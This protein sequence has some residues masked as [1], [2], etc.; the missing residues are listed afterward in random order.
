MVIRCFLW[1]YIYLSK[2]VVNVKK[3]I[4]S[5]QVVHGQVNNRDSGGQIIEVWEVLKWTDSENK[6]CFAG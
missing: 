5:I 4:K 1:K 2:K 3:N 6:E